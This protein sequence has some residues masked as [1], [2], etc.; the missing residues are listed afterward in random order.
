MFQDIKMH[1]ALYDTAMFVVFLLPNFV[2]VNLGIHPPAGA[3]K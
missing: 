3:L 2:V 1:F